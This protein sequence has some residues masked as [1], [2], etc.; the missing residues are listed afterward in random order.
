MI[1]WEVKAQA[2][3]LMFADTD[4][5][6]SYA[7]FE[8]GTIYSN[9]N[10]REKLMRMND[11]IARAIDLYY[12]YNKE[13]TKIWDDIPLSYT[14]VI[15]QSN[16]TT[17]TLQEGESLVRD[18]YGVH[19]VQDENGATVL[20]NI[21]VTYTFTNKLDN[22]TKPDNFSF[23]TRIDLL[24]D[25]SYVNPLDNIS[26]YYDEDNE[27]IF[28]YD[29]NFAAYESDTVKLALKF[30]VYY[31]ID[32]INIDTSASLNDLTYD[33]T[34]NTK[35]PQDVQRMIPY[36]IKGE[37]YEEDEP[38][39][40]RLAKQEYMNFIIQRPRKTFTK[41]QTKVKSYSRSRGE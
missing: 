25:K 31:K 6:F 12:H 9:S 5:N 35:V 15:T 16:G 41:V 10:T 28:F 7:E 14:F 23:P 39:L 26:Y 24:E 19:T 4:V 1:L 40:A 3:R 21:E 17:Y 32:I 34:T 11:S 20:D 36:F 29:Q 30:R 2:L 13:Q 27:E 37:L 18:S 22:T 8:D 33:L 38:D